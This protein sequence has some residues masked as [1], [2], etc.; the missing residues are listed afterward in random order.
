MRWVNYLSHKPEASACPPLLLVSSSSP[1]LFGFS[2]QRSHLSISFL[3]S[4][5]HCHG[6]RCVSLSFLYTHNGLLTGLP[7]TIWLSLFLHTTARKL[8]KKPFWSCHPHAQP[9]CA[10]PLLVRWPSRPRVICPCVL[11]RPCLLAH[12]CSPGTL[13]SMSRCPGSGTPVS[14]NGCDLVSHLLWMLPTPCLPTAPLPGELLTPFRPAWSPCSQ[15]TWSS[16][17]RSGP[18]FMHIFL[19]CGNYNGVYLWPLINVCWPHQSRISETRAHCILCSLYS[20]S[21]L[22][23]DGCSINICKV[24]TYYVGG[25]GT[26]P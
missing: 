21:R 19:I 24:R 1:S 22:A 25:G 18:P 6:P 16:Q 23:H 14:W 13:T 26:L 7:E 10:F 2:F 11:L 9:F 4:H 3:P 20:G 8:F 5:H 12:L 15:E 17:T